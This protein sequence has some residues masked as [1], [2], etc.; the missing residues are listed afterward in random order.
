VYHEQVF[1]RHLIYHASL[2]LCPLKEEVMVNELDLRLVMYHPLLDEPN[3]LVVFDVLL[4][5]NLFLFFY[6][7]N[8]F[9]YRRH[10][11]NKMFHRFLMDLSHN[12]DTAQYP[13][14]HML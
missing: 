3:E 13:M 2:Y 6:K 1:D 12:N 4:K 5:N 8:S 9:I 10:A 14:F 11:L 7:N